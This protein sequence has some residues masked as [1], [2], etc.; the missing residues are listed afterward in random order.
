MLV[1]MSNIGVMGLP[2]KVILGRANLG[3]GIVVRIITGNS[4][5]LPN[6]LTDIHPNE[7]VGPLLLS[8]RTGNGGLAS[9]PHLHD[10]LGSSHELL[11]SR[12]HTQGELGIARRVFVCTGN[13]GGAR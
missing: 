7:W 3:E 2:S 5:I 1:A 13:C 8:D 10:F 6:F 9:F 11:I 4:Y 12:L